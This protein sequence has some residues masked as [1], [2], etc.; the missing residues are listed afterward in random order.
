MISLILA[1]DPNGGIGYQNNLPWPKL[2]TD[3][4]WFKE[5]TDGAVVVMGRNTWESLPV[6]LS[7]RTT[8]V[9]TRHDSSKITIE[10][11]DYVRTGDMADI[12]D[13]FAG[14][15]HLCFIGGKQIYEQ[16]RS[17]VDTAFITRLDEVFTCDTFIDVPSL[18]YGLKR[19]TIIEVEEESL[20]YTLETWKL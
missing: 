8:V 7:N 13:E 1:A 12:V 9:L 2:K 19:E 10:G 17:F 16:A 4:K 18:T 11:P 5:H 6:R 14:R 3:M 20:R 15:G